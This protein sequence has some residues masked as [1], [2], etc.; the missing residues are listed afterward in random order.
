MAEEPVEKEKVLEGSYGMLCRSQGGTA[1]GKKF[2]MPRY[3]CFK[4]CD[5]GVQEH[6]RIDGI[7]PEGIRSGLVT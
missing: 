5:T 4:I 6:T 2:V 1:A 3:S 7:N